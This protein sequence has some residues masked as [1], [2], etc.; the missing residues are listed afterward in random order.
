MLLPINVDLSLLRKYGKLAP[1][2]FPDNTVEPVYNGH[3]GTRYICPI[4]VAVLEETCIRWS[5]AF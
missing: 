4:Q 2:W 5:A 1:L 3:L